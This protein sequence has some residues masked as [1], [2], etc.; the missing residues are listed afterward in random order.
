[1]HGV[2]VN[3]GV[4]SQEKQ[5]E[6]FQWLVQLIGLCS[7]CKFKIHRILPERTFQYLH[8]NQTRWSIRNNP[9]H[10]GT[11]AIPSSILNKQGD[12]GWG[13][14]G[15][16][17]NQRN[18]ISENGEDIKRFFSHIRV[19][20][21]VVLQWTTTSLKGNT[22]HFE[23]NE[24]I[25]AEFVWQPFTIFKKETSRPIRWVSDTA[26]DSGASSTSNIFRIIHD[27][28]RDEHRDE[29]RDEHRRERRSTD[30]E[31]NDEGLTLFDAI[32]K[33]PTTGKPLHIGTDLLFISYPYNN[34][35][36]LGNQLN[37]RYKAL[38]VIQKARVPSC[39]LVY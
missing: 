17:F 11:G 31:D 30:N 23:L 5:P 35:Q 26:D 14:L 6:P 39:K 19:G 28:C 15:N 9:S 8:L 24:G 32:N 16:P 7:R 29:Y 12:G 33:I 27:E 21:T 38:V 22:S 34:T 20:E 25:Q 13:S 18:V 4:F 2:Q 3:R 37:Q 36:K 10:E 1:M